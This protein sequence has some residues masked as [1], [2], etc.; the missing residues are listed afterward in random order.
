MSGL[1]AVVLQLGTSVVK[2]ATKVWFGDRK[3]AA[4]VA[5]NAIDIVSGRASS[6]LQRREVERLFGKMTDLVVGKLTPII[7]VEYARLPENERV[8]AIA[9]VSDT[10]EKAALTD[11]DLFNQDLNAGYLDKYLR[12]QVPDMAS[13]SLLSIDARPFYDLLLR[14]CCEY[15]VQ[16]VISLPKFQSDALVQ[17]LRR[18][19]EI[20]ELLRQVLTRLPAQSRDREHVDFEV[21]YRRQVT[22]TLDRMELFGATLS[23]GSSRYPLSVAY[24]SLT[25]SQKAFATGP[26]E[27][28]EEADR[29]GDKY[30]ADN[31]QYEPSAGVRVEHALASMSRI[32]VQGDAGSGK[33]TLLKWIAVR[34]SLREFDG[35]LS[36][37]NDTVPFFVPLRRYVDKEPPTPGEF[38][39]ST[40]RHIAEE[41]PRG[42]VQEQMR[43]GRAI[44]LIDGVDELPKGQ[45][46][47]ARSWLRELIATFP[48]SRYVVTSRSAAASPNWLQQDAFTSFEI[49]PMTPADIRAFV[50]QWHE[51]MRSQVAEVEEKERLRQY[52]YRLSRTIVDQRYLRT[53]AETP[54]L[55]ALLC[56]LHYDRRGR[57]P[58]NKMEIYRVALD[59]LLE[60]RDVEREIATGSTLSQTTKTIILQGI[61]YWLI[62]NGWTDV[63]KERVVEYIAAKLPQM[64]Q[65]SGSAPNVYRNLLERSGIIR[66]PTAGRMD[67]VHKTFQEYL[68]ALEL[69]ANDDI[70][71]LIENAHLDEWREVFIMA[72]GHAYKPKRDELLRGLLDRAKRGIHSDQ[73]NLLAVASL[74]VSPELSVDLRNEIR[75][76]A[77]TLLPPRNM[78]IAKTL[79][80]AGDFVVDLLEQARPMHAKEAAATIRAAALIGTN[81]SLEIITRYGVD[82]RSSVQAELFQAW[83]RFDAEKYARSVLSRSPLG[84]PSLTIADPE[85]TP[86]LHHLPGLNNLTISYRSPVDLSFIDSLP[87]LQM[88]STPDCKPIDLASLPRYSGLTS[89]DLSGAELKNFEGISSLAELRHLNL[90]RTRGVELSAIVTLHHL[91][92]LFLDSSEVSDITALSHLKTL[93]NLWLRSLHISDLW[94]LAELNKIEHLHLGGNWI[95]DISHLQRLATLKTLNISDTMLS[96]V[97]HLSRLVALEGLD[98]SSNNISDI[99][100]LCGLTRLKRFSL[101]STPVEDVSPLSH[102]ISLSKLDIASTN[103]KDISP[104]GKL[105]KLQHLD[106]SNSPIV[107]LSPLD[108]LGNLSHLDISGLR[109]PDMSPISGLKSL[110][111]LICSADTDLS[112]LDLASSFHSIQSNSTAPIVFRRF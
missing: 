81:A 3:V 59:M 4:D 17:M 107:D 91:E 103:V 24:I 2:S 89:L 15:L 63:E 80:A 110:H 96:S 88:L 102:L 87:C 44:V 37:W 99:S 32:F 30:E 104:L 86:Y 5:A 12:A 39:A 52:E 42:W 105:T 7:E 73:L 79:A 21:N 112:S 98:L 108:K 55:S 111:T 50:H 33:T 75:K 74:E 46:D 41:M 11:E 61:A 13:K 101:N 53:L 35:S 51:A 70:G 90:R 94:P 72:V 57:P 85:L 23:E 40:G 31:K 66:E 8:A 62:R 18:D 65:V 36:S 76:Q 6:L 29:H 71:L 43:Q 109:V 77:R 100:A 82:A 93:K 27:D 84:W 95:S 78:T 26:R 28:D 34:S 64:P 83:S 45:R 16:V 14:E 54:L 48:K 20:I 56:A 92:E 68:A 9:A 47:R 67:F 22:N 38:L 25:V 1:E 58:Q 49:Q 97:S 106:I 60:R 10:F 19:T 69:L